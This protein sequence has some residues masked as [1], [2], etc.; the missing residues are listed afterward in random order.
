MG[1]DGSR[2]WGLALLLCF[3]SS[4]G[5]RSA[6]L[7]GG[8]PLRFDESSEGENLVARDSCWRRE[9]GGW[10]HSVGHCEPM[11]APATAEGVWINAFEEMS[12]IR[13]ARERPDPRDPRRYASEIE[14]DSDALYRGLGREPDSRNGEAVY[15]RFTGRRTREPYFVDCRGTPSFVYVVERVI[16]ARFLGAMAPLPKTWWRELADRP[17]SVKRVHEG[18][19]GELEA[20]AVE[21]C[22][23]R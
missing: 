22:G 17:A 23:P 1:R 19:W 7:D 2:H 6:P 14:L 21:R 11:T 18:R 15:L 3:G 20:E 8:T 16:E 9:R 12:F 5:D 13:G 10:H 4:C